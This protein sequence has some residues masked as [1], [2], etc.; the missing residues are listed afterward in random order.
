M[1]DV[2]V[3]CHTRG[4]VESVR[5][6]ITL[7]HIQN[8][9]NGVNVVRLRFVFRIANRSIGSLFIDNNSVYVGKPLQHCI[10]ESPV[11][12][13]LESEGLRVIEGFVRDFFPAL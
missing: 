7:M 5:V 1:S 6:S 2:F 3:Y 4:S 12:Y 11:V 8:C 10:K 13:S 9:T